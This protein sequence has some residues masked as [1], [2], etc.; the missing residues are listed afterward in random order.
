MTKQLQLEKRWYSKQ[1]AALYLGLSK[2]Y[3]DKLR[4]AGKITF[5]QQ[6]EGNRPMVYF[7]KQKL[8]D[9]MCRSFKE[10]ESTEDYS[11]KLKT[12]EK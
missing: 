6:K 4:E 2:R 8:D 5:R 3:L 1:E 12:K 10:I 11:K 7:E 9:Y